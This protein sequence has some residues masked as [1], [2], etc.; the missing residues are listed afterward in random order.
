MMIIILVQYPSGHK[1]AVLKTVVSVKT[2]CVGSNPLAPANRP[3][4][5]WWSREAFNLV[6]SDRNRLGWPSK[7]FYKCII[8][9]LDKLRIMWYNIYINNKKGKIKLMLMLAIAITVLL[10]ILVV[11]V[12]LIANLKTPENLT[13]WYTSNFYKVLIPFG[14]A[15]LI[16]VWGIYFLLN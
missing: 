10:V 4:D 13:A 3:I 12:P 15:V 7:K 6:W 2:R 1:G 5:N 8:I 11:F 9:F 14:I 16:V